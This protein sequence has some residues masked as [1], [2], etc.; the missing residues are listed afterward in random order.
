MSCNAC[1]VGNLQFEIKAEGEQNLLIYPEVVQHMERNGEMV[2]AEGNIFVIKEAGMRDF[3]DFCHDHMEADKVLF[4]LD[5]ERW[6]PLSETEEILESQWIDDVILKEQV[7][8]HA[9]P[10]LDAEGNT[11]AHEM[12]ARFYREDG[13]VP[14]SVTAYM[15]STG[16]AEW[17]QSGQLHLRT[18]RYSLISYQPPFILRNSA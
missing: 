8:C 11:Y 6:R 12:L 2:R 1:V 15:L 10:I 17:L 7:T 4:R 3:L 16:F 13:A 5:G 9:Q 18:R 14:E